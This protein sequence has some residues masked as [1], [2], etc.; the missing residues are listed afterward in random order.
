MHDLAERRATDIAVHGAGAVE[1]RAIEHV[2]HFETELDGLSLSE[3]HALQKREVG[4]DNARSLEEPS[5]RVAQR[6]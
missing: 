6:A 1:L 4:V 3:R 2:E 5:R